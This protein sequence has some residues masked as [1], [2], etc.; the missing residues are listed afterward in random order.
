[1]KRSLWAK[2][3][4]RRLFALE[5]D[6]LDL[7][8]IHEA[9]VELSMESPLLAYRTRRQKEIDAKLRSIRMAD[10]GTP[11]TRPAAGFIYLA[12]SADGKYKIGH[13]RDVRKRMQ[14]LQTGVHKKLQLVAKV[15]TSNCSALE[16]ICHR[17]F[18]AKRLRG[19]WFNLTENDIQWVKGLPY[20]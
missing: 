6:A 14:S 19:E 5:G 12:R 15:K 3:E 10:A 11:T 17:R 8:A 20:V 7:I 18:A 16:R 1:M 9:A 2:R 13:S 4:L